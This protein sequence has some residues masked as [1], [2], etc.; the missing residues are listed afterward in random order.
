MTTY[1]VRTTTYLVSERR[2]TGEK[3]DIITQRETDDDLPG[4]NNDMLIGE[5][6]DDDLPGEHDDMR[7][8]QE[9]DDDLPG[10]HDDGSRICL[11]AH[12]PE[13]VPRRV[14]RSLQSFKF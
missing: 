11:P 9:T 14:E 6:T 2:K 1:L 5:E 3:D 12:A 13:V 10:E 8:G 4:E 7:I